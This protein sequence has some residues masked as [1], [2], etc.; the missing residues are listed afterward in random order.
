MV[1]TRVRNI[2]DPYIIT[3][4]S[5]MFGN[6]NAKLHDYDETEQ[7]YL[8]LEKDRH[9]KP[10]YKI[11]DNKVEIIQK[12]KLTSYEKNLIYSEVEEWNSKY[13]TFLTSFCNLCKEKGHAIEFMKDDKITKYENK[14]YKETQIKELLEANDI[15]ENETK[16]LFD[17]QKKERLTK[18]EQLQIDKKEL[19]KKLKIKKVNDKLI[20]IR[21]KIIEHHNNLD[22][23]Y[24]KR[25]FDNLEEM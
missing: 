21:K 9:I 14:K 6:T 3:L 22:R 24:H 11:V 17:K 16:F 12:T 10:E 20:K 5:N 7:H 18:S 13:D 23:L 2:K 1:T 19:K 15:D 8:H 25:I 4:I